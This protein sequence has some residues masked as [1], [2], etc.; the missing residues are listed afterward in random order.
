M[1]STM[2]QKMLEREHEST[3]TDYKA[4]I[5]TK[6]LKIEIWQVSVFNA[7]HNHPLILS[8]SKN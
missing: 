1:G 6:L 8:P 4:Y 7:E 3:R 2:D 5:R